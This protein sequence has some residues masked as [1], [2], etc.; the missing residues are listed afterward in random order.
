MII[1]TKAIV[2]YSTKYSENSVII[3]T[4]TEKHGRMGYII[5]GKNSKKTVLRS[6]L[7]QPLSVLE[8]ETEYNPK[9]NIQ[10]IKESRIV[11]PFQ[12]IPFDP[13]KNA[14]ALFMSELLY[15]TLKEP[16]TDE[17]LYSFLS[18]AIFFLDSTTKSIGNFHLVFMLQLSKYLGFFP[19][20]ETIVENK[21]FDLYNGVFIENQAIY[22]CLNLSE[23]KLL[24]IL[25]TLNFNNM[26]QHVFSKKEKYSLLKS[27]NEYYKI[28]VSHYA[29]IKSLAVMIQLFN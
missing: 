12:S 17:Y 24:T 19:A 25:L 18:D 21:Y 3:H 20:Q 16:L 5:H 1:K 26:S 13:G 10:K 6:A 8:I 27:L 15:R 29:E 14:L 22:P 4:Y 11:I 9:K 28:H 23:S 7:Y 2:I